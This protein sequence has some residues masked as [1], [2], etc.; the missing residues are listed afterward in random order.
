MYIVNICTVV[1]FV[2][3]FSKEFK[4]IDAMRPDSCL[5]SIYMVVIPCE[6]MDGWRVQHV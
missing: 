3:L 5:N 6:S 1:L 2:V 4:W